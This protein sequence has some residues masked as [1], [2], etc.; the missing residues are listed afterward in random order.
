MRLFNR[1]YTQPI[2]ILC[3][4]MCLLGFGSP[5]GLK[6]EDSTVPAP[7]DSHLTLNVRLSEKPTQ[8]DPAYVFDTIGSEV[9]EQ[10]FSGLIDRNDR[11]GTLEPDLAQRWTVSADGLVYTFTLHPGLR[12]S[13]GSPLTA[14]DMRYSLL[15]VLDPATD[16]SLAQSLLMIAGAADFHSGNGSTDDVGIRAV[17][18]SELRIEL[19][20]PSR[21]LLTALA[22]NAGRVVP[23]TAIEAHGEEWTMPENLLTSG[24]YRLDSATDELLVYEKNSYYV[25]ANETQIVHINQHVV[26]DS[27]EAW[28]K[29]QRGELDTVD[30]GS[31]VMLDPKA[32]QETVSVNTSCT[33]LYGFNQN[34]PPF[35]DVLVRK[36]FSTALERRAL[37]LFGLPALTFTPP[38][39]SGHVDGIA[40]GIGLDRDPD[41]AR[42]WLAEAGY[43]NGAGLPAIDLWHSEG[44]GH[45]FIANSIAGQWRDVLN[46]QVTVHDLPWPEMNA[47][48]GAGELM[49]WRSGWCADYPDG[50]SYLYDGVNQYRSGLGDWRD[51]TYDEIV[52]AIIRE[53]DPVTAA[54]LYAQAEE[55]LVETSAVIVPLY[56][57]SG[58]I[59][60]KFDLMR[61]I[62]SVGSHDFAEWRLLRTTSRISNSG[63][64][65]VS[66]DNNVAVSI[67]S[68]AF[69]QEI[70]LLMQPISVQSPSADQA[71][72]GRAMKI[73]AVDPVTKDAVSLEDGANLVISFTYED[74]RPVDEGTL[75]LF[76]WD[77]SA[78][79]REPT[80]RVNP[81]ANEVTATPDHLSVWAIFG[82]TTRVYVP[83]AT[84]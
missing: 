79:Q 4:M 40:T 56:Y 60:T 24:P 10:L 18:P 59:A 26:G 38:G 41:Q 81:A 14:E 66:S 8:I 19:D 16:S 75:A 2:V 72:V 29:Y 63:G 35:D 43:P 58:R 31:N 54:G 46:A 49:V 33:Y 45:A 13:D 37:A 42:R 77:G 22:L 39:I 50:L 84:K 67:P 82:E 15:R 44:P 11:T 47:S 74:M 32:A 78:W 57:Y 9:A 48:I 83:V 34:M 21:L 71:L 53:Q 6:G 69:V 1:Q 76:Y 80:S 5:S 64:V 20:S 3:V 27:D 55:T 52:R 17:T 70:D 62:A 30:V 7:D 12:W 28:A 25:H 51:E 23:R 36:A 61:T 68:N 73:E 65:A